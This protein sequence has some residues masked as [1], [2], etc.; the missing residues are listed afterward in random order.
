[1]EL[2]FDYVATGHYARI[3][4]TPLPP[5]PLGRREELT[6]NIPLLERGGIKGGVEY[7]LLKGVDPKKDQSYFLCELNQEQLSK[8]LFPI[9]E[10]IKP[11]VREMAR[12]FGLPTAEKKD[13]Q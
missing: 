12:K 5:S 11:Q 3:K 2:G 8:I 4:F 6:S 13:S 1:M 7:H 10:Y 9:G